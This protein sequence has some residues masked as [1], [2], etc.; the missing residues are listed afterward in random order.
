MHIRQHLKKNQK[1]TVRFRF[2][3][4]E[5]QETTEVLIAKVVWQCGD[6]AGLEFDPPLTAGSTALQKAPQLVAHLA[7]KE[8]GADHCKD[9]GATGGVP[10]QC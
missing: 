9:T 1:V 3:S 8:A 2:L 10:S 6:N 4:A 5:G 7:E